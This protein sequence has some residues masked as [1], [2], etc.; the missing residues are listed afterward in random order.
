MPTLSDNDL[1]FELLVKTTS[2]HYLQRSKIMIIVLMCSDRLLDVVRH[3]ISCKTFAIKKISVFNL[4]SNY[5]VRNI[6]TK[7]LHLVK[8]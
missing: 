1:T 4:N 6:L 5:V 7:L 2:L 8:S 3:I